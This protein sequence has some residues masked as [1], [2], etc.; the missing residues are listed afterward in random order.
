[1]MKENFMQFLEII[2]Y[3]N[4]NYEAFKKIQYRR[5]NSIYI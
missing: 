5:Y 2:F 1:M 4:F 3:K